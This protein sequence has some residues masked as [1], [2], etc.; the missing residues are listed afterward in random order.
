MLRLTKEL[1]P[2]KCLNLLMADDEYDLQ[3]HL[4]DDSGNLVFLFEMGE[5]KMLGTCTTRQELSDYTKIFYPCARENWAS[6]VDNT[7]PLYQLQI[8]TF[9]IYVLHHDFQ[10][11]LSA[12]T[13]F[14][15]VKSTAQT[16]PFTM[17]KDAIDTEDY[18]S[19]DHCQAGSSKMI[20]QIFPVDPASISDIVATST[21]P[22]NCADIT[23]DGL[24]CLQLSRFG[25]KLGACTKTCDSNI[26]SILA[27]LYDAFTN[28]STDIFFKAD[29]KMMSCQAAD[30]YIFVGD[31][32]RRHIVHDFESEGEFITYMLQNAGTPILCW[33]VLAPDKRMSRNPKFEKSLFFHL[34]DRDELVRLQA[35]ATEMK[36]DTYS[37]YS[38][39][40]L[41]LVTFQLSIQ[42]PQ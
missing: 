13:Q 39:K 36:D 27:Y 38:A 8:R 34:P 9:P 4:L 31:Q 28:G 14:F 37:V 32:K 21:I 10:T 20:S 29:G 19:A 7:M 33:I 6:S 3:E 25:N 11:I 1:L 15:L 18:V 41:K 24:K 42:I 22:T 5:N 23:K 26:A 17:S 2:T 16:Y 30:T 35:E 12:Q 40:N